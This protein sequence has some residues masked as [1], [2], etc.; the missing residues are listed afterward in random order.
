MNS[1]PKLSKRLPNLSTTTI[2]TVGATPLITKALSPRTFSDPPKLARY[3]GK[4]VLAH[5]PGRFVVIEKPFGI[6]CV[7]QLQQNGGVFGNSV[8]DERKTEKWAG[9]IRARP[10]EEVGVTITDS[11][12]L[13]RKILNEPNLSFCTGLKRYLSGAIVLPCN[14]RDANILKDCIRRMSA[15][16]EPPFMYNALAITLNSPPK[17]SGT[18]TGFSTFRNVGK[19]VEYI[20]EERKVTKRAKT[21]KFAVEGH[22]SYRVLD[23][24]NGISL[25]DFSVN[26][27][28]RHLP[29]LML[30]QMLSPILGDRIYWRRLMELDGVPELVSAGS[31][32]PKY[33]PFIPKILAERF[34]MSNQELS[35]ALPIYCHVYNTIFEDVGG[36]E[37]QGLVAA[38]EPPAHFMAALK[39][40]DLLPAYKKFKNQTEKPSEHVTLLG[41]ITS[42]DAFF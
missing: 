20:F 14:E 34:A 7:G 32:V 12:K 30:T 35:T 19:H 28:A 27:F 17:S 1:V 37:E 8:R 41:G 13:L 26:K 16:V 18:I 6:S 33:T 36:Y 21:G 29:R 40:L 25:V 24:R 9:T 15:D 23:T 38:V 22:M 3:L 39:L 2:K 10:D 5:A 4:K 11:L 42:G 31:R